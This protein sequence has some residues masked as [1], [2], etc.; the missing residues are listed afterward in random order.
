[1]RGATFVA[2]MALTAWA[3]LSQVLAAQLPNQD[4]WDIKSATDMKSLVGKGY[5]I[6]GVTAYEWFQEGNSRDRELR[7]NYTL[8]SGA[9]VFECQERHHMKFISTEIMCY[10]LM[11][12]RQK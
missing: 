8:Q 1:M 7:K 4:Q 2:V 11:P 9:S 6:V 12:T 3:S 5:Q 10:E